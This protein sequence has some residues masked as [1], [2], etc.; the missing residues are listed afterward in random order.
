M[1]DNVS[2]DVFGSALFV[3]SANRRLIER[4]TA[5]RAVSDAIESPTRFLDEDSRM[6]AHSAN[7]EL[8]ISRASDGSCHANY[9][10]RR[11]GR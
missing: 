10:K 6:R 2:L 3:G 4:E 1:F 9:V 8:R 11:I 5:Q 7:H